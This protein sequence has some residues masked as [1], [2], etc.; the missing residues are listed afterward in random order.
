MVTPDLDR[1]FAGDYAASAHRPQID[2]T[3]AVGLVVYHLLAVLAVTP[4][5]FSWEGVWLAAIGQYVFGLLGINLGF[6]RLLTHR[7]L[8]CPRWLE[9][10]LAILGVCCCQDAPTY[11]VAVHR[12]HHQFADREH[13]PHSPHRGWFWAHQ[14]WLVLKSDE[15][16]RDDVVQRYAKDLLRDPFYRW[17]HRRWTSVVALSWIAFFAAGFA[18]ALVA[19]T[20]MR[21]AV[22]SGIRAVL[23]GVAVRTVWTWHYTNAVNS[24]THLW[25]YRNYHTADTSRNNALLALLAHGE[26]WHNNHHA[27]Q[28]S[29]MH[30]HL[31]W[32]LDATY[33]VIRILRAMGLATD[34]VMPTKI[35]QIARRN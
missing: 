18:G 24:V 10:T 21:E 14:G 33:M 11:W 8:A 35:A 32:E 19:G 20:T 27:D 12:R 28:K 29:A 16:Q 7:S 4:L 26:G 25:G 22:H 6:H 5:F 13:D 17:L 23:W 3:N 2:W 9:R 30:G 1:E 34:V 15:L 31:W